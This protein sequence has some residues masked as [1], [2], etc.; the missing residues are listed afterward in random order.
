[1]ILNIQKSEAG[2][3]LCTASNFLGNDSKTIAVDVWC[4][5][6]IDKKSEN[7]IAVN[8]WY[9]TFFQAFHWSRVL[10]PRATL[11][12]LYSSIVSGVR[13]PFKT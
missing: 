2:V 6:V 12:W 13:I 7:R 10:N 3:Y 5:Y 9:L 4:E 11:S 1:M 8:I